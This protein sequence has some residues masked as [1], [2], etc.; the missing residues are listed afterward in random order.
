MATPKQKL[1]DIYLDLNIRRFSDHYF[2]KSG[3]W[4][5]HKFDEVD[6]NKNGRP[7]GFSQEELGQLKTGLMDFA[8]RI[9]VAA[10]AL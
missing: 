8:Q 4:L 5:Y 1:H 7:D 9:Q 10:S 6:V 3:S 2:K